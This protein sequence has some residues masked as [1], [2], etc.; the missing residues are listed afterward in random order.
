MLSAAAQQT[1]EEPELLPGF[2]LPLAQIFGF[3]PTQHGL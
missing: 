1:L 3:F 2:S